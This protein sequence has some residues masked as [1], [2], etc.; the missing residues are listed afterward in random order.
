MQ[1][2]KPEEKKS[3]KM[4]AVDL[5]IEQI[6]KRDFANQQNFLWRPWTYV[7]LAMRYGIRLPDVDL[8]LAPIGQKFFELNKLRCKAMSDQAPSIHE[9][10]PNQ[11]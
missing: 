9:Y 6:R 3:Q 5:A 11:H 1:T 10:Y 8:S 2:P 7:T 4:Q